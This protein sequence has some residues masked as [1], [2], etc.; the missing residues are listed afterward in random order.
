MNKRPNTSTVTA[1][2]FLAARARKRC[3]P[4]PKHECLPITKEQIEG[5]RIGAVRDRDRLFTGICDRALRGDSDA[6][7]ACRAA[8]YGLA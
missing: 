5:L 6:F 8:V 1:A 7:N 3:E 4:R 2:R